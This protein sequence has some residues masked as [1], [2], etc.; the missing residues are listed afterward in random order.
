MFV[1]GGALLA[2][3]DVEAGERAARQAEAT[4]PDAS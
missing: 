2:L 4:Q 1:V 3:V